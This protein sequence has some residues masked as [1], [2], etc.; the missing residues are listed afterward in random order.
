M[1]TAGGLWRVEA[2]VSDVIQFAATRAMVG[3]NHGST[4]TS[5]GVTVEIIAIVRA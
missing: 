4:P 3:Q 2:G 1:I 5:I